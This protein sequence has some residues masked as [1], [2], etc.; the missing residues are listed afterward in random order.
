MK[1]DIL[2]ILEQLPETTEKQLHLY[3]PAVNGYIHHLLETSPEDYIKVIDHMFVFYTQCISKYQEQLQEYLKYGI[4]PED[5][6]KLVKCYLDKN[7]PQHKKK[8]G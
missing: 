3:D 4:T 8:E 5:L 7:D 1:R 2:E 6:P